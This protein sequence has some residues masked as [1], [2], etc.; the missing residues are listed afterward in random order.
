MDKKQKKIFLAACLVFL[1]AAIVYYLTVGI[2]PFFKGGSGGIEDTT[3]KTKL[4]KE[5][6]V[7]HDIGGGLPYSLMWCGNSSFLIYG[8]EFGTELVD[9]NGNTATVST[10]SADYPSG[11]T[12]DGEWVIF[13]SRN[14]HRIDKGRQIAEDL[15]DEW[16]EWQGFV[17]DLYRYE[18]A[19]GY[20]QKFAVVRD[21]GDS[22]IVSPDGLKIF[23]GGRHNSI[24]EMPD[25]KWEALWLTDEDVLPHFGTRWFADSSGIATMKLNATYSLIVEFFGKNGWTKQ[26]DINEKTGLVSAVID[27]MGEGNTVYLSAVKSYLAGEMGKTKYHFFRCEIKDNDLVCEATGEYDERENTIVSGEVLPNGDFIFN[28]MGEDNCIRRLKHG[29]TGVECIVDARYGNETYEYIYLIAV[30]PDGKRMAFRRGKISL[31]PGG[32]FYAYQHDLFVREFDD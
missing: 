31:K 9:F 17:M 10:D 5:I 19:T 20:R 6:L 1:V 3:G 12:P 23:L 2:S 32:R 28:R 21:F 15:D 22:G 8:D 25:P 11:C 27:A 26:F 18:V 4:G 30:S 29:R 14:S 13:V 16:T 7:M 24:M